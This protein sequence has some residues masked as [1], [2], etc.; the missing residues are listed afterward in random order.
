MDETA[1]AV[2]F[3][4]PGG[5]GPASARQ[6]DGA[7]HVQ[8]REAQH[9]I[10]VTGHV[11]GTAGLEHSLLEAN[12]TTAEQHSLSNAVRDGW[13]FGK[14]VNHEFP[15]GNGASAHWRKEG[16]VGRRHGIGSLFHSCL[17]KL[18][19]E[20]LRLINTEMARTVV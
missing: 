10:S 7:E 18:S 1:E 4:Q 2:L 3:L 5:N 17:E 6:E 20:E 9:P 8:N 19:C 12:D 13:S 11:G 14:D 16:Q 15:W